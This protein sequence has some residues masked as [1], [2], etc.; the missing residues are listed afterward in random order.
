MY[1]YNKILVTGGCGA[2][3]SEVIN[4]LKSKYPNTIFLNLDAL[5][6]AGNMN[7]IEKPHNN[8]KFLY[9]NICDVNLVSHILVTEQPDCILHFAAETHVD[10][11]FGNS[12]AFTQSNIMGTHTLLECVRKYIQLYP[13]TFKLFLH[14]STD[15]VYGSVNED[16]PARK[17][18]ALFSP[19]NPY[20][21]TKAG[22]EMLCH[23]YIKSFKIPIIITRCNNAISKYQHDEK[24]IPKTITKFLNREKM[25]IQGDGSSKRTFIHAYDIADAIDIMIH[26][27]K[28]GEIYN[29]GTETTEKTVIDVVKTIFDIL[30]PF[31]NFEESITFVEDRAFQDYRYSI[32]STALRELGWSEKMT[33]D[34]A[35]ADVV[36]YYRV[37]YAH[38]YL[39]S[40]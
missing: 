28:I 32:D 19:S 24:L 39:R 20:S 31:K 21:A 16:E 34:D 26:K 36:N 29:I 3:G 12:F 22:A 38:N 30:V 17:E 11:S 23:A 33:F 6:Y 37:G 35:I 15:E 18:T 14:M 25:T 9:G 27:G 40:I 1:N 7:H 4:R 10:N 5:T 2:I 13:E 8:Y